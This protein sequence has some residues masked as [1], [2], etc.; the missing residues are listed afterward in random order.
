[1]KYNLAESFA[2]KTNKQLKRLIKD[3]LVKHENAST[4]V[5]ENNHFPLNEIKRIQTQINKNDLIEDDC[6]D[7][8]EDAIYY[9]SEDF[10][11]SIIKE[12]NWCYDGNC[13][14][15]KFAK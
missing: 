4:F 2:T 12:L 1:M 9:V 3:R 15:D 6:A 14:A 7:W 8:L 11:N 13:Y 10:W 5:R